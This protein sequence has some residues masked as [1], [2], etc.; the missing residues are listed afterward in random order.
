MKEAG[1]VINMSLEEGET[2][3]DQCFLAGLKVNRVL[4]R[5]KDGWVTVE[6]DEIQGEG[7]RMTIIL[8]KLNDGGKA[9]LIVDHG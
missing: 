8:A 1:A 6:I 7:M 3:R 2:L 5:N 9:T 4:T